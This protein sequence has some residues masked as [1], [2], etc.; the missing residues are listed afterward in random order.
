[1]GEAG[2]GVAVRREMSK[3]GGKERTAYSSGLLHCC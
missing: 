3:E 1:M 2:R